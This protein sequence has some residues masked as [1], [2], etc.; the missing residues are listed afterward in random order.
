MF[1]VGGVVA[2]LRQ[3]RSSHTCVLLC[4]T[5]KLVA[6]AQRVA[7]CDLVVDPRT[8]VG[9][10]TRVGN[11]LAQLNLTQVRGQRRSVY[12]R[13]LVDVAALCVE[14]EGRLLVDGATDVSLVDYGVVRRLRSVAEKWIAR[15]QSRAVAHD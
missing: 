14:K 7:G 13:D 9:T 5:V 11:A 8:K 3:H 1:G 6:G 12:D 2:G 10:G 15:V 4:V